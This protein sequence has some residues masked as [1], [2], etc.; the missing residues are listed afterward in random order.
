VN[1]ERISNN[2]EFYP[3]GKKQIIKRTISLS[4]KH[5][6]NDTKFSNFYHDIILSGDRQSQLDILEKVENKL[7]KH[8]LLDSFPNFYEILLLSSSKQNV[9]QDVRQEAYK[10][11]GLSRDI[12][13][14]PYLMSD[15]EDEKSYI[16]IPYIF[17]ALGQLSIDRTGGVIKLINS[18]IDDYFDETLVINALYALYYI[19]NYTNSE[20]VDI[21]FN[22]IEKILNGGY[23][24]NIEKR[25]YEILKKIK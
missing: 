18:R 6:W 5:V 10:L 12:S 3:S 4:D 11:I 13:F 24:R 14:L 15:L 20:F 9:N 8:D 17:Y 2:F 19:N 1:A 23:S 25:C 7:S 22:G 16:L 21:V